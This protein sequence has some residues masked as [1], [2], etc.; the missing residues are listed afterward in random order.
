MADEKDQKLE[1]EY[2]QLVVDE[3]R[4]IAEHQD[5]HTRCISKLD[6]KIDLHIQK[7]EY[8]L[9]AINA[10]D[11]QQN[12]LIDQHIEGVKGVVTLIETHNKAYEKRFQVLEEPAKAKKW[13]KSQWLT[14][15]SVCAAAG[16]VVA[17]I[18]K[19]MG[20]W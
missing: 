8:E 1:R 6:K 7:T 15:G 17:L 5:A 4:K 11:E 10:L 3:L 9:K 18:T 2:R 20:L 16:S 19:V 14:L 13:L 12:K